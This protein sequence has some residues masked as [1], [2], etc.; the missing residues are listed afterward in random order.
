MTAP[1]FGRLIAKSGVRWLRDLRHVP[2]SLA[3]QRRR[4]SARALLE[5][6]KADK[7]LFICHGNI[8]RSPFAAA[9]FEQSLSAELRSRIS[10]GSAGFI[11][12]DRSSP[13]KAIIAAWKYGLDLSQ[14]RSRVI[15]SQ[16]LR[17]AHL[18]V[19]MSAEQ[20]EGIRTRLRLQSIPVLVL[21]DLDPLPV[22]RRTIL[23]PWDGS[24]EVFDESYARL[25]RCV[26]QL[27]DIVSESDAR[28][29][30]TDWFE[31]VGQ[32]VERGAEQQA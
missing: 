20:A 10:V 18:V 16:L 23:D 4:S 11:G 27:V 1:A 7:I 29:R 15:T 8:C 30:D 21:G 31:P 13:L 22:E 17:D 19:V 32:S 12:P 5:T 25:S 6:L 14:H 9:L 26:A 24:D 3:H 2:D 28:L